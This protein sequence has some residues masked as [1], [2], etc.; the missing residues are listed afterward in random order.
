MKAVSGMLL[1]VQN[2][3]ILLGTGRGE[4][5]GAEVKTL[6]CL[7]QRYSRAAEE[8]ALCKCHSRLLLRSVLHNYSETTRAAV[9]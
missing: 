5:P 6:L 8:S 3:A 9:L 7:S 4:A 1:P 2:K